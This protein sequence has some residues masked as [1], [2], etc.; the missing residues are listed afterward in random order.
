MRCSF[1]WPLKVYCLKQLSKSYAQY[2]VCLSVA[3]R[4]KGCVGHGCTTPSERICRV[5]RRYRGHP[6]D[7][8]L[9]MMTNV[10]SYHT[11]THQHHKISNTRMF[12][13]YHHLPIKNKNSK[14]IA[15]RSITS[16]VS[17]TTNSTMPNSGTSTQT[18]ILSNERSDS[19]HH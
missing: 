14:L 1:F 17:I 10:L 5:G 4:M 6:P 19:T 11:G 8:K 16:L 9:A 12:Y 7:P 2:H 13:V 15:N 3:V 18:L